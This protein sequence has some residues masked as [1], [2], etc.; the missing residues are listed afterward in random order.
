MPPNQ[1]IVTYV[2]KFASNSY[3]YTSKHFLTISHELFQKHN[4]KQI[5]NH[6]IN[7]SS[8]DIIRFIPRTRVGFNASNN[9]EYSNHQTPANTNAMK[10]ANQLP[11][12]NLELSNVC[13]CYGASICFQ[14]NH[15]AWKKTT[16]NFNV[17][18]TLHSD[19][20]GWQLFH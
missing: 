5:F 14:W 15:T 8:V 6:L 9:Q 3:Y 20:D 18:P 7:F 4:F 13:I 11:V 19:F 17:W 10:S 12:Q 2:I 1:N 16:T